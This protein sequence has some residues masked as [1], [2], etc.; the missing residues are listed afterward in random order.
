MSQS[1]GIKKLAE[2]EESANRAI[3]AAKE[4][5]Q[6]RI[7]EAKKSAAKQLD[8]IRAKF[9]ADFDQQEAQVRSE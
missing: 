1:G 3:H 6:A 4:K 9:Q 5:R 7:Q 8:E 2:A